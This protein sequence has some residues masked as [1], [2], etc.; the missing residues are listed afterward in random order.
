MNDR[1]HINEEMEVIMSAQDAEK[2]TGVFW[3]KPTH[4]ELEDLAE[5]YAVD[6]VE[7]AI[8]V[9]GADLDTVEKMLEIDRKKKEIL[10][11][12]TPLAMVQDLVNFDAQIFYTF[13]FLISAGKKTGQLSFEDGMSRALKYKGVFS[14]LD[15]PDQILFEL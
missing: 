13:L 8:R 6:E 7:A 12:L 1:D 15:F 5:F 9:L 11:E 4:E 3:R 2:Y 10:K 14:T